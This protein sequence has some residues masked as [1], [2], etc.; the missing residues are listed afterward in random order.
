M[1]N[2][3]RIFA[4]PFHRALQAEKS[5]MKLRQILFLLLTAL[6]F[7]LHA[8]V[9]TDNAATQVESTVEFAK[10]V[11]DFGD[12]LLSDGPLSCTFSVKNISDSP[13]VI[14]NVVSS[15]GCTD[16]K[17]TRAPIAAGSTG[18]ISA[19][20]SND[21]GPYPFDKT[22]TVYVSNVK[23]PIILRL[24]G[25][26]HKQAQPLSELFPLH[27]GYLAFKSADIK[28][29]NMDMG[30]QRSDKIVVANIGKAPL[31]IEFRDITPG[32][33]LT[34]E[35]STLPAGTTGTITYT[36]TSEAGKWGKNYYYFTPVAS[37]KSGSA[38][39]KDGRKISSIG[40]WSFTKENFTGLTAQEREEGAK[41][42]FKESTYDFGTVSAGSKVQATYFLS[43]KGKKVFV[44]HKAD[45]EWP[46]VSASD[47]PELGPGKSGSLS[48]TLDT[49]GMPKGEAMV[50]VTLV[51]NSPTRPIV[52]LY[53]SGIIS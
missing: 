52:N 33:Q 13:I 19:T 49:S 45:S 16:V 34:A 30:S 14:Y 18:E 24:R 35:P 1:T 42:V 28:C 11:H 32:L 15:C 51:T 53:L 21:E 48:V 3:E 47:F 2:F 23:K 8:Q 26:S 10:I 41:P 43:N 31:K 27:F 22:L 38:T 36:I 40:I 44:I 29:G 12:V 50:V 7:T 39:D 6:P 4:G 5:L 9:V 46:G 17:W 37:G 20:Y 25:F